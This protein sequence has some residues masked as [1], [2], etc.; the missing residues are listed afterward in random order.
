MI[1][2][3]LNIL[4]SLAMFLYGMKI[5][6]D[7]IQ[8]VA[9]ERLHKILDYMTKNRFTAVLTGLIITSII[10]SSSATTVMIVSF[11]NAGLLTLVKAIGVIMG[12][13]IGTTITAW[14][15]SIFGFKLSLSVVS[16][17]C[18]GIG[19]FFIFSKKHKRRDFGEILVGFGLL[20]LGL[21][22][23]KDS[24]PTINEENI[25]I[26]EFLKNFTEHGIF[27][28]LFFIFV[29]TT[30]TIVIQSSS[31]AMAITIAM[32]FNGWIDFPTAAAIVLGEN[33]GTTIT[34]FLAAFN[35]NVSARRAA[36]AHM[37]FNVFGVLWMIIFFPLFLKL[38]VLIIPG[39][40]TTRDI[41]TFRLALFHTMFNIMNTL[42]FIWF[43]PAFAWLVERLVKPGERDL[44][45]KYK[46]D[47]LS[48]G[49]QDTAEI[50]IMKGKKEISKMAVITRE[51]FTTFLEIFHNPNKNLS[52]LVE[53]I[54]QKEELTDQM[55][56]EISRYLAECA[57][58][59]LNEESADNVAALLRIT[60]ELESIGDSCLNLNILAERRYNKKIKLV[61]VALSE[62]DDYA[63]QVMEFINFYIEHLE[64]D[65]N[66]YNIEQAY[67]LEAAIDKSRNK[68]KKN[69]QRRLRKGSKVQGEL[70]FI[71]I[72]RHFERIGDYSLNISQ[73]L[74][75]LK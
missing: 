49:I 62:I 61:K 8:K 44:D 15:V 3:L 39:S 36:R 12:A 67:V 28:T 16:L 52:D 54:K 42:I 20:F 23:L 40:D 32:A 24:V 48:T 56:E 55:Q 74:K 2:Q 9:G 47:Y 30:I 72:I 41:I 63:E 4:G 7:G 27:S 68:L 17:P 37:F 5:M 50:N 18:I 69:A 45:K 64:N 25:G 38:I 70:L 35:A 22:F 34:A 33:I 75:N 43:V 58:E 29:G 26:L 65:F 13:N 1:L 60:H 14:I 6:S 10:Q 71:D 57:K 59:S 46:L 53:S 51:M 66:A 11:V 21:R 31:A 73:A 19:M